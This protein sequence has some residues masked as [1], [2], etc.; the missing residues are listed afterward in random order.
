MNENKKK[1]IR[2]L[3]NHCVRDMWH[4]GIHV[5]QCG[6]K[7]ERCT[8]CNYFRAFDYEVK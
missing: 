6:H 8:K 4:A 2:T 1:D 5:K 7:M 3:C